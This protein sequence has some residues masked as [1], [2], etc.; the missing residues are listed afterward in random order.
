VHSGGSITGA[1][2]RAVNDELHVVRKVMTR[3]RGTR[4]IRRIFNIDT[5]SD[6]KNALTSLKNEGKKWS[7]AS[8]KGHGNKRGFWI[9]PKGFMTKF[10]AIRNSSLLKSVFKDNATINLD[11]CWS[12]C[13]N[14]S[15][16]G[17]G[18]KQSLPNATVNGY[19]GP[20]QDWGGSMQF[21]YPLLD[22]DG[23]KIPE[24]Y[25]TGT[26]EIE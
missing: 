4:V 22:L 10:G 9:T 18:V 8:I 7:G 14:P 16:F 15:S 5:E 3:S 6:F 2:S 21:P 11:Y 13:Q 1:F 24:Y 12:A 26:A 20:M 25:P 19:T 23:N 17:V